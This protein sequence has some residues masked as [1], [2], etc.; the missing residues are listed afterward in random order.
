MSE[1]VFNCCCASGNYKYSFFCSRGHVL[2]ISSDLGGNF[3]FLVVGVFTVN[4]SFECCKG[5]QGNITFNKMPCVFFFL[6]VL[7]CDV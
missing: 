4:N 1:H 5:A 6:N 2:S 3:L 7:I